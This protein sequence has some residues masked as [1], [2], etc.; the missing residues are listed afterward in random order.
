MSE[1]PNWDAIRSLM[2]KGAKA[3]PKGPPPQ[4][5]VRNGMRLSGAHIQ[6]VMLDGKLHKFPSMEYVKTLEDEIKDLRNQ[7]KST[8]NLLNRMVNQHNVMLNSLRDLHAKQNRQ[9]Y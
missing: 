4:Y 5:Q 9:G 3:E 2:Y 1:E 8:Q 7:L 6:E